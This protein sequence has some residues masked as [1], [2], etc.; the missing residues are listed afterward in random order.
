MAVKYGLDVSNIEEVC[1]NE[2]VKKDIL[3]SIQQQGMKGMGRRKTDLREQIPHCPFV[4]A[5]ASLTERPDQVTVVSS[6]KKEAHP[7]AALST[8]TLPSCS[9][10]WCEMITWP[11]DQTDNQHHSIVFLMDKAQ[12]YFP[13]FQSCDIFLAGK[14]E[15]FEIPQQIT[16]VSEMWTPDTGLVTDAFKLKRKNIQTRYQSD[17]NRMYA[18]VWKT[19]VVMWLVY[20]VKNLL[21]TRKSY[22]HFRARINV[23]TLRFALLSV[24]C[25]FDDE[26]MSEKTRYSRM[27]SHKKQRHCLRVSNLTFI[28]DFISHIY[29][30]QFF[31]NL[32]GFAQQLTSRHNC[33]IWNSHCILQ[34]FLTNHTSST[35]N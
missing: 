18:W 15:K 34:H 33:S 25:Q 12:I 2:E 14:L 16:L 10:T 7:P 20:K 30:F 9:T 6:W 31:T 28:G 32:A 35:A 4:R 22:T 8:G 1:Q 24:N 3:K 26:C 11:D 27:W 5:S 23:F 19:S 13:L 21:S 17:I 29:R